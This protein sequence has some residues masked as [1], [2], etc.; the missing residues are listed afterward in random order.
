VTAGASAPDEATTLA[1]LLLPRRPAD[2]GPPIAGYALGALRRHLGM[3]VAFV[4]E[5]TDGARVLR[6]V[7][8]EDGRV[9]VGV[10]VGVGQSVPL[11][12]SHCQRVVDGRLPEL[13]C[14][15]RELPAAVEIPAILGRPVGAFLSVPI[16]LSGGHVYGT[17]CCFSS[18]ADW[19]L[20]RRD[21]ALVRVFAECTA[22]R[23]DEDRDATRRR[24]DDS[25]RLRHAIAAGSLSMVFQ[26]IVDI[27]SRQPLGFEALA[28]FAARPR[29]G[30]DVWF[31]EAT[32]AGLG[33]D[34][35]MTAVAL[36]LDELGRVPDGAYLAVNVS[37]DTAVSG[38][39][40]AALA[41]VPAERIVLEIT[42]HDVIETYGGLQSAL[43]GLRRRGVRI[44]VDDAGAGYA[45]FRH[46]LRLQPDLIKLD[47]TL[48]R[49]IDRDQPR[50]ALAAAMISFARDTCAAIVAEGVETAAEL[51]TLRLLGVTAAQ[52]YHL[53]RPD[54]LAYSGGPPPTAPPPGPAAGVNP[55]TG[56]T[57]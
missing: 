38:R 29:R 36:A 32:A 11:Q 55:P 43:R 6:A 41:A 39:L 34:A 13:I 16:R 52:G 44:A 1:C 37:P 30:P 5:F 19:S 20:T 3:D 54:E 2:A 4:S 40:E 48:T 51:R 23:I 47:V 50:R 18:R 21:L 25:Q 33:V 53:G 49:R 24:L 22:A 35:E 8:R 28:R 46:I 45:S 12:D 17:L 57:G 27:D 15:A 14:D 9:A 7:D 10:G 31:A 26:P 42:E 56:P